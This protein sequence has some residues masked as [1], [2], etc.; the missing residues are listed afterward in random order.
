MEISPLAKKDESI[1]ADQSISFVIPFDQF[2]AAGF[3]SFESVEWVSIPADFKISEV[4]A[5]SW[6]IS[7]LLT[8]AERTETKV[9]AL[10]DSMDEVRSKLDSI[11]ERL[12]EMSQ[13][14]PL[15]MTDE[16]AREMILE[17]L[18]KTTTTYPSDIAYDLNLDYD[19]VG[20]I[21]EALE[22]EGIVGPH[23]K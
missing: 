14:E 4:T 18:K 2:K 23:E 7:E 12:G 17:Y 20:R 8:V 19:Q 15:E 22:R 11:I 10:T 9:D 13:E 1:M 5:I 3:S 16:Q 6:D 21:L